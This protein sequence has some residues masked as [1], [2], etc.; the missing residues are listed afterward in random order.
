MRL[1]GHAAVVLVGAAVV[2]V[3]PSPAAAE[4]PT[5]QLV[6]R[7]SP[8]LMLKRNDDLPCG[9]AGEQY[10][11]AP[12][13]IML[14]NPDVQL[15]LRRNGK[16]RIV[17]RAPTSSDI[18]GLDENYYL[19]QPG[20]PYRPGCTFARESERLTRGRQPVIYAHLARQPGVPRLALQYW[21]YYWFNRFN[22]LHESD[23]EGI[24]LAFEAN[25]VDDALARGPSRVAYAQ[26]G[27]GELA[28]W[29]DDKLSKEGTH[30]VVYVSSGSHASQYEQA[31]YLGRGRQGSGLG[32]DD[33]RPKSF[34]VRPV[35]ILVTTDRTGWLTYRGHWGQH[36]RG[37][38][39]GVTGPIRK[40]RWDSPFAWMAGLRTSTPEMPVSDAAGPTVTTFFCGAISAVAGAGHFV[41]NRAWALGLIL[42]AVLLVIALPVWRTTWRPAAAQPLRQERAAGQLLRVAGRLYVRYAGSMLAIVLVIVAVAVGLARLLQ[43]LREN[44]GLNLEIPLGDPGIDSFSSLVLLAPAYPLSLLLVGAPFIALLR[45]VDAGEPALPWAAFREVIPLVPRLLGLGLLALLA[46]LLLEATVIGIPYAVKKGVDWTFA[47]QEVVFERRKA[48]NAL[49]ASSRQ[50]HGRWWSIAGVGLA[51]FFV[52]AVLG[53][54]GGAALIVLTGIPLWTINFVGL[55]FFALALPF[56]VTAVTLMYLDPRRRAAVALPERRGPALPSTAS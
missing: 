42:A 49:A 51:L 36:A 14:G 33:T 18:A 41:G 35:P 1:V 15:V 6:E 47:G 13:E 27:G 38:S 19:N 32:C 45:R 21:F 8:I 48:R 39:N 54:L 11:P 16:S 22:D 4:T 7:Y 20:V 37:F 56:M 10:L 3:A 23:W 12:V 28:N 30:P 29:D 46:L 40:A 5:Q 55:A 26:H 2:A 17:K 52:G 53:P 44:A 24:Q 34:A 25:S 31:L 43:L 9:R 50:V